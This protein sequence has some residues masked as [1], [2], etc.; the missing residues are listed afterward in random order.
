[1]H[2]LGRRG[3]TTR[4]PYTCLRRAD[5]GD[6]CTSVYRYAEVARRLTRPEPGPADGLQ[7]RRY[8]ELLPIRD[9]AGRRPSP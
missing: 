2:V 4:V 5:H 9:G 7:P 6:Y 8:R 1:M 3:Y